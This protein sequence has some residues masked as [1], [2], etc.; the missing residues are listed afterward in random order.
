MLALVAYTRHGQENAAIHLQLKS[1]RAAAK[2]LP[3]QATDCS[4]GGGGDTNDFVTRYAAAAAMLRTE[5]EPIYR[6]CRCGGSMS[7]CG[8]GVGGVGGGGDRAVGK[9]AFGTEAIVHSA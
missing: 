3:Q 6:P 5:L 2:R 1:A 7:S 9:W 4:A 8:A